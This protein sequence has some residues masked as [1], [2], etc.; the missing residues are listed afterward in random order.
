M[1][2]NFLNNGLKIKEMRYAKNFTL[3]EETGIISEIGRDFISVTCRVGLIKILKLQA[4]SKKEIGA[5]EY[6]RG[7]RQGFG[8]KLV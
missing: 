5:V 3:H 7:K 4:P 8:S 6:I 2:W 1:A